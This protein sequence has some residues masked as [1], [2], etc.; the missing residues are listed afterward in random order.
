[1]LHI[2]R[3]LPASAVAVLLVLSIAGLAAGGLILFR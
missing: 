2:V 3:R 1:M